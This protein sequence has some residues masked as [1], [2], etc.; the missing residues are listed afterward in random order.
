MI[1]YI[2][3]GMLAGFV[4]SKIYKKEGSGCLVNLLLGIVGGWVGGMVLGWIGLTH[5]QPWQLRCLCDWSGDRIMA[6]EQTAMTSD[7]EFT[8]Q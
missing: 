7:V 4:A 1:G 3:I 2:I 8:L 6:L 5:G